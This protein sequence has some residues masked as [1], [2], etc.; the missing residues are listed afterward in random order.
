VCA[1]VCVCVCGSGIRAGKDLFA[2]W[3]ETWEGGPYT[4]DHFLAL[5]LGEALPPL[6]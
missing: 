3:T 2:E 4:R 1:R 5:A 6:L